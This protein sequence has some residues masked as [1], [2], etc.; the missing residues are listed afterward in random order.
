MG[1]CFCAKTVAC[2]CNSAR[3]SSAASSVLPAVFA[4][5]I[6]TPSSSATTM[7][8]GCTSAPAQTTGMLTEPSVDFTAFKAEV[9]GRGGS[10]PVVEITER[11]P[12]FHN[13]GFQGFE[14][15]KV[16]REQLKKD[17]GPTVLFELA[18]SVY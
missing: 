13:S 9:M 5:M 1:S 4:G 6:T 2:A 18:K 11:P 17:L 12:S 10:C 8:P 7:S 16:G 14:V 3:L 15:A